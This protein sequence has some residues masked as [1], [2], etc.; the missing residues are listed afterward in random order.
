[1]Q[2]LR[3]RSLI[4]YLYPNSYFSGFDNLLHSSSSFS[5]CSLNNLE[6]ASFRIFF[7]FFGVYC[8]RFYLPEFIYSTEKLLKVLIFCVSGKL[9]KCS[10]N[11]VV[12]LNL[13]TF[14]NYIDFLQC[15][16][17]FPILFLVIITNF[18]ILLI[19]AGFPNSFFR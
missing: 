8:S 4:L 3:N 1:M 16:F 13:Q 18:S 2:S 6:A 17:A 10:L 14:S 11:F 12:I 5:F 9:I 19:V 15:Q 7:L